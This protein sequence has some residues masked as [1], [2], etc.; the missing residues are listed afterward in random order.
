MRKGLDSNKLS[1]ETVNPEAAQAARA[2][3]F[4]RKLLLIGKPPACR[5][6]WLEY[7]LAGAQAFK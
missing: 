7:R 6:L 3:R 1:H 5:R 4:D 2:R